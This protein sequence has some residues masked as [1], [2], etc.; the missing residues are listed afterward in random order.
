MNGVVGKIAPEIVACIREARHPTIYEV[1]RLAERIRTEVYG[2]VSAFAWGGSRNEH[3][4]RTLSLRFAL[5]ALTGSM[6]ETATTP[7]SV[8]A[9]PVPPILV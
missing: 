2:A 4:E 6:A 8:I 5:A 9:E 7:A 1:T 3:I